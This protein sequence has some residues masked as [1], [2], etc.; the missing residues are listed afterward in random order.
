[1]TT[2]RSAQSQGRRRLVPDEDDED[3][4]PEESNFDTDEEYADASDIVPDREG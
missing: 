3:R 1:M 2:R 4:R